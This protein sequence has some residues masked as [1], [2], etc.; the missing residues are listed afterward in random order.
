MSPSASFAGVGAATNV[1]WE[2]SI[3]ARQPEMMPLKLP[4]MRF[5]IPP[6]LS[7]TRVTPR[8]PLLQQGALQCQT[9]STVGSLA[10]AFS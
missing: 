6:S 7:G 5:R 3:Q 8:S 1:P 10:S 4:V 2:L 9:G